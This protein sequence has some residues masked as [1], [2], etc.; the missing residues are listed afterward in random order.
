MAST[1]H[2]VFYSIINFFAIPRILI[3]FVV[4]FGIVVVLSS[5]KFILVFY[6]NF[7]VYACLSCGVWG[8]WIGVLRVC[9]GGA[10]RCVVE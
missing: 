9:G 2:S 7:S 10:W 5:F 6:S 4:K 1:T 8:T 3:F